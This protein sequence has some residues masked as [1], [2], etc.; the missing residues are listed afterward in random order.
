MIQLPPIPDWNRLHPLIVH[1]PI[2]LLLVAPVFV[3][4]GALLAPTKGRSF[5]TS[6]LILMVMGILSLFV[7]L[8]TGDAASK[9]AGETVQIKQVLEQHEKFAETTCILFAALTAVFAYLV[10][11]PKILKREL[12][13]TLSASLLVAFLI[14]YGTGALFLVNTAHQG[15]RLVHE[16][17]VDAQSAP[18]TQRAALPVSASPE[19]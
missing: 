19:K 5:L 17:A 18:S 13:R 8:E 16:F 7:A 3:I 12:S 9:L 10:V 14:L 6:A 15:G 2:A 4:L 11:L 1:F